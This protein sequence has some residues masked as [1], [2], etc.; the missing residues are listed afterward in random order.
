MSSNLNITALTASQNNKEVT[1]ND[2]TEA[3]DA[4]LTEILTSDFTS[5][6]VT[7]TDAQLRENVAHLL[8]N[9]TVARVFTVPAIKHMFIVIGGTGN[10]NTVTVTRGITTEDIVTD[11]VKLMYT[12]GTAD[13]LFV[14]AGGGGGGSSTFIALTDTPASLT[15]QG[16][17]TVKVNSGATALEFVSDAAAIQYFSIVSFDYTTDTSVGDGAGYFHIPPALNGMN[18]TYIHAEV[19]TAGVTGTT[20]IQIHNVTGTADMLSTKLTIDTTETGSDTATTP[21]VIDGANDDVTTNDLI[22]I[23]VDAVS[24]TAAKGLLITLGFQAP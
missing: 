19:I 8:D 3:L 6:D 14:I 2:A 10:T 1:V 16:G 5:A 12:D 7:L 17:K 9:V 15:G 21:A 20:D 18:L 24:T 22:R 13:G 23:D 11:D 4:A